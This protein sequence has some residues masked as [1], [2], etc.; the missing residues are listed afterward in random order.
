MGM[1]ARGL[2]IVGLYVGAVAAL[3]A[4]AFSDPNGTFTW[5]REVV[6][7]PSRLP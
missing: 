7:R 2:F 1:R 5:D 3:T 4:S 6:A